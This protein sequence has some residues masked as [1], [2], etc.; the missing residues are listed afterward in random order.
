[1]VAEGQ[2]F[3]TVPSGNVYPSV[4]TA[5]SAMADK[6]WLQEW[7]NRVGEDVAAGITKTACDRGTS[8]HDLIFHHFKGDILNKNEAGYP[9]FSKLRIY[10][11]NIIPLGLEIPLWSDTL[12]IAGRTDCIGFYKGHLSIIDYKTSRSEKTPN[13]ILNYFQQSA[14]YSMML[15]ERLDIAAKKI[16]ILI[17]VDNG[18]PQE[19]IRDANTYIKDNVRLIRDYHKQYPTSRC[20]NERVIH[21]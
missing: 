19:F 4:T 12:R 10:L 18:F 8:M 2:R 14:F 11:Q 21:A 20:V 17:G 16:V 7:K 6:S 9:L 3:Y 1:M 5:L 15:L 13:Q